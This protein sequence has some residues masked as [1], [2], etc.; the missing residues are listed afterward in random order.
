MSYN[1]VIN[2]RSCLAERRFKTVI[3]SV[4][5]LTII[6]YEKGLVNFE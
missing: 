2:R 3:E 6:N 4:K 1:L 5:K